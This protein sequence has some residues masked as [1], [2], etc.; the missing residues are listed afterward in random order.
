MLLARLGP[1]TSGGRNGA[2]ERDSES[3]HRLNSYRWRSG[4]WYS[5]HPGR[6]VTP[7]SVLLGEP[8]EAS[9]A[10]DA[11][12]ARRS[13]TADSP[14]PRPPPHGPSA[15]LPT[16]AP[17]APALPPNPP[18]PRRRR[19]QGERGRLAWGPRPARWPSA[20]GSPA[21]PSP[22]TMARVTS[23]WLGTWSSSGAGDMVRRKA[24]QQPCPTQADQ[25]GLAA[26]ASVVVPAR[27]ATARAVEVPRLHVADLALLV[28]SQQLL[29]A[30]SAKLL[31]SGAEPLTISCSLDVWPDASG[32][33]PGFISAVAHEVSAKLC[34]HRRVDMQRTHIARDNLAA[35]FVHSTQ[36]S[37]RPTCDDSHG[38]SRCHPGRRT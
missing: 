38:V 12:T 20:C 22:F 16:S 30:P 21:K 35:Q 25:L 15:P 10:S 4:A 8:P 31:R 23:C 5:R 13:T 33:S 14:S 7:G 17:T 26:A 27:L 2:D 18:L 11:T 19:Q 32:S 36:G 1:Y 37:G 29:P 28:Q 6:T 34:L 9:P 3:S 24:L